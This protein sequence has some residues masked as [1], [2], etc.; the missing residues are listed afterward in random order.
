MFCGDEVLIEARFPNQPAPGLEMPVSGLS[1]LW[2]TFGEFAIPDPTNQPGRVVS[3]LL[4]GQPEN[5]WQGAL[6]Y[7]IHH[8]G[9]SAQTGVIESSKPGE[10]TVGDRTPTWWSV[11]NNY[12]ADDGRGMIVGHM[13]A[14]DQPGE[15]HWQDNTLYLIPLSGAKP[16][17][18][19]A[20]RRHLALDL[21][22][23]EHIRMEG[24][25]VHAASLRMADTAHCV[26]DR[27]ELNYISHYTRLYAAGQV[28]HGRDTRPQGKQG[29]WSAATTTRF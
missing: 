19:A 23:R 4:E 27:C 7:G 12:A 13:N 1:R 16:D 11:A 25:N 9:W 8:G 5:Y 14:L 21:S 26:V 2:P 17:N 22:G 20:K 10:I 24:I 15:W 3:K 28:E 6:Y 29:S 18:V